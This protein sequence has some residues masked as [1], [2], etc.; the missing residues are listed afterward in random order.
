MTEHPTSPDDS[1]A[2]TPRPVPETPATGESDQEVR[3]PLAVRRIRKIRAQSPQATPAQ[4]IERLGK[5]FTRDFTLVGGAEA[6][7]T[8]FTPNA[9]GRLTRNPKVATATRAASHLGAAGQKI[10][11]VN[12]AT[13]QGVGTA[14]QV[15][16]A[17]AVKAYVHGVAL[18]YGLNPSSS[19]EA[20]SQVLGRDVHELLASLDEA[21]A[22]ANVPGSNKTNIF[23]AAGVIASRN[24]KTFLLV[25]A[26]EQLART[27]SAIATSARVRREFTGQ[28]IEQVR[29]N[30]GESPAFFPAGLEPLEGSADA[31]TSSQ[32]AVK[33]PVIHEPDSPDEASEI[34]APEP[35]HAQQVD[36]PAPVTA[37]P[38]FDPKTATGTHATGARFA[39]RAFMKA[40]GRFKK[41]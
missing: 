31:S 5:V 33:S 8:E 35:V 4:V 12:Q 27:G 14:A 6:G 17:Q 18:L 29:H 16:S 34:A 20:A 24:P 23:G 2:D 10:A 40:S 3:E 15:G 13:R 21:M 25:K 36:A 1:V 32:P 9:V 26:G 41:N 28:L 38:E 30:L 37:D 22:Q 7:A 39:A 19:D 11:N